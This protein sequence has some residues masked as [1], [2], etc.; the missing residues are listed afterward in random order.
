[1]I[2][3]QSSQKRLEVAIPLLVGA[4]QAL[5]KELE[6][7]TQIADVEAAEKRGYFLPDEDERV[8][9][10]YARYH[11][12]RSALHECIL[13]VCGNKLSAAAPQSLPEFLVAFAAATQLMRTA[14]Y[15]IGLTASRPVV[16]KKLDEEEARYGL[17]RKSY[18]RLYQSMSSPSRHFA[19]ADSIQLYRERE[20][21]IAALTLEDDP[22]LRA[23][24][25]IIAEEEPYLD[26]RR[27]EFL[28]RQLQYRIYSFIRRHKSGYHKTMF[29]LF[30]L[31]GSRI[32]ELHIPS[33]AEKSGKR[34]TD[35]V[36]VEMKSSLRPGDV[37]ITRHDDAMSN[38][39]LPGFWP[40]AALYI[41]DA[42]Q[43]AALGL[44]K[45]DFHGGAACFVEAKKDGVK[46][47]PLDDTFQVDAFMV[48]RPKLVDADIAAAIRTAISHTGKLY[49]FVFD[50]SQSSRLACTAVV[51]RSYHGLGDVEFALEEK[52]GRLCLSAE[53]MIKQ[54]LQNKWFDLFGVYGVEGNQLLAGDA[55][56]RCVQRSFGER[57]DS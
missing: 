57:W 29:Q 5:P 50:F 12:V 11:S 15:L 44:E 20:A 14:R 39:F 40:H 23:V 1:M 16:R 41:G 33:F 18:T 26:A 34:V 31:S 38:L 37:I 51:Y 6:I 43:R 4:A 22:Q 49:D 13:I 10:I 25:A 48:M 9:E 54:L 17:Q 42:E 32:A 56:W 30:R 24:L 21:E 8:L 3:P 35:A 55:A 19:Y 47:R 45:H 52:A 36:R 46:I 7:S 2:S 28:K 53:T 27:R